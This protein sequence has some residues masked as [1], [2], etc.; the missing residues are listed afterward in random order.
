MKKLILTFIALSFFS[1]C[2]AG[3]IQDMHKAVIARK[4]A[5]VACDQVQTPTEDDASGGS[6]AVA[7]FSDADWQATQ[8]VYTGTNGK[9][10]CQIDLWLNFVGSNAHTYYACIYSDDGGGT[11]HPSSSLGC[12]DATDVS[13]IGGSEVQ[14][15]FVLSSPTSA[16]TN[17]STYWVVS[18]SATYDGDDY[19]NWY[20]ETS[21][22]TERFD[23]STD[24]STWANSYTSLT[25]K[26]K[27][28]SE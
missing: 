1:V 23:T 12:S 26:Y 11:P 25:G 20:W 27:L 17:S 7:R 13:G 10:I 28:Y 4:N 14:T 6:V 16:L 21:G 18:Y 8:F 22:T 5:V 9:S 3:S 2:F 19:A 15:A 24:G